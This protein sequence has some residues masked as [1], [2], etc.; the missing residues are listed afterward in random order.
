MHDLVMI[1]TL[2]TIS[3][4]CYLILDYINYRRDKSLW[5]IL[6]KVLRKIADN[7]YRHANEIV[8]LKKRIEKLERSEKD[9]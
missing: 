4:V 8:K 6:T 7:D 1:C 3:I 9:V 5:D 2:V